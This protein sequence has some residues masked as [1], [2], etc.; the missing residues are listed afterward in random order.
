VRQ[1][2]RSMRMDLS[3]KTEFYSAP[4]IPKQRPEP[5]HQQ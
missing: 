5:G 4:F 2:R 3:Q 1:I